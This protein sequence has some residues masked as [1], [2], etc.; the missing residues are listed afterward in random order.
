[1]VDHKKTGQA[2]FGIRIRTPKDAIYATLFKQELNDKGDVAAVMT[3]KKCKLK[4]RA[5]HGLSGH[6]NN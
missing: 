3:N 6:M 2:E 5:V 1:M 4:A